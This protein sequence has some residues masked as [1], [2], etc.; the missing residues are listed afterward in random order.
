MLRN[1]AFSK[2]KNLLTLMVFHGPV[3]VPFG[4]SGTAHCKPCFVMQQLQHHRFLA[5]PFNYK[6]LR[7]VINTL[8]KNPGL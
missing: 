5:P 8:L 6:S 7:Q 2:P 1:A 3:V 4:K